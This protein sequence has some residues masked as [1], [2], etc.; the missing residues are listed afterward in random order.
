LIAAMIAGSLALRMAL[1]GSFGLSGDP[2]SFR[3][4]PSE[5][6]LFLAGSLG[7]YVHVSKDE[8]HR[9]QARKLLLI[10][11]VSLFACLAINRWDGIARLASLSLLAAVIM[12]T[13]RLFET[14]KNIVWDKYLGELSYPLYICHFL[15]GWLLLPNTFTTVYLTLFLSLAASI[16][17]YHLV[18]KPIDA[19][20]QD[21]LIKSERRLVGAQFIPS[22]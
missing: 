12:G 21:R 5:I 11:A 15:F 18:D 17:L 8:E 20:R 10:S 22:V 3:F 9:G 6:A 13:P 2:W 14:T 1:Q 7:Y 16:A 4:F 19:W